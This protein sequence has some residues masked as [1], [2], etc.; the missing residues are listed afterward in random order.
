MKTTVQL[1]QKFMFCFNYYLLKNKSLNL[2][3]TEKNRFKH[4]ITNYKQ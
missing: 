2:N 3:C 4:E 1:M